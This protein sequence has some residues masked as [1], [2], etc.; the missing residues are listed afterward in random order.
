MGAFGSCLVAIP[1][2]RKHHGRVIDTTVRL[3]TTP[4]K[5]WEAWADPEQIANWF[6]DRASGEAKAG[7]TMKWF[8]DAFHYELDVPI[9][10]AEP[11]PWIA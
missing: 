5:A 3:T 4:M 6:V 8:F 2:K 10:E 11:A 9:I 1:M 7:S